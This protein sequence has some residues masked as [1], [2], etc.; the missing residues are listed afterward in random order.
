M[1]QLV[2][3]YCVLFIDHGKLSFAI[4]HCVLSLTMLQEKGQERMLCTAAKMQWR[5]G[6]NNVPSLAATKIW[7]HRANRAV[8]A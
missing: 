3:D 5:A 1:C 8:D 4:G 2:I 7:L 6:L